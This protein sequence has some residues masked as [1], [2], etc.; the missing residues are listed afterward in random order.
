MKFRIYPILVAAS[1]AYTSCSSEEDFVDIPTDQKTEIKFSMT[2]ESGSVS[3]G[4]PMSRAGFASNTQIIARLESFK[5]TTIGVAPSTT[6]KRSTR[7]TLTAQAQGDKVYSDVTTSDPRYWDDCYGR[8]GNLSVYAV[9]VPGKTDQENG[10]GDAKKQLSELISYG[11][12]NVSTLNTQWKKDEDANT[13]NNNI[14]WEITK[15]ARVTGTSISGQ[16]STTI[17]SEDLCYSNN[18][19]S[20]GKN[21][22]YRWNY[23]ANPAG[24][25]AF[26]YTSGVE[27]EYPNF[28]NGYLRFTLPSSSAESAAG[29]FDKGHMIFKH[30]LTRLTV[31]LKRGD[32][33]ASGETYFKFKK[34]GSDESNV[35]IINVPIKNTLNIQ[36]GAWSTTSTDITSGSIEKMAPVSPVKD[37]Y[38]YSL[39][40]QFIPGYT[41]AKDNATNV[42]EFTI[43]DNTYYITQANIWKALNEN[44]A[45]NG[46]TDATSYTMEQ[47]KNY[48]LDIT[49]KKTGIANV[50]ATLVGWGEVQAANIDAGNSY[51]TIST[52][53]MGEQTTK[54]DHFDLWRA[55]A[56]VTNIYT[57]QN[58][59]TLPVMKNW[60]GN[61][62]DQATLTK[63]GA[64]TTNGKWKT[65]WYWDSNKSFYHF[66]TVDK[67]VE[68]NGA[69][70]DGADTTD[71]Y[72]NV[73]SGPAN[74]TWSDGTVVSTAVNDKKYNDYHWG[75][76]MK[77]GANLTYNVTEGT[78]EGYSESLY[79]AIGSTTDQINIIEQHMM[80]TVHFVIHTGKKADGTDVSNAAVQLL[81][82]SNN[83]TRLTLT[84]FYGQGQ[85]K[86]GNG[87]ITPSN[88][89]SSDIPVPGATTYSYDTNHKL[90]SLVTASETY[91]S[92]A[93]TITKSYDYRVVPQLLYRGSASD[94]KTDNTLSNFVGL[95]IVTPDNNQYYVIQKLYGVQGTVTSNGNKTEHGA[96]NSTSAITRWYPGYDYTYHIYINKT[97]I[98]KITC[99]VVDW[100]TVTG[101]IGDITLEN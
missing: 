39:M 40:A 34:E 19:M 17:D 16:T 84:N 73:F 14:T 25:P 50:T 29:H 28:E 66:R 15:G 63:D 5:S 55:D 82:A 64:Y 8:Y 54:C 4:T 32:G 46:L 7:M 62:T 2:D 72:F 94:P 75:A 76:P 11:G 90:S 61:Y 99:T 83:G 18:I 24:Y 30:A 89:I 44:K 10:T 71:D 1:L 98:D 37:T 53:T 87:F 38:Q 65:N 3:N 91:F 6:D 43:D 59:V 74:E 57:N 41:F 92:T 97:G 60:K 45:T 22:V 9:A 100:A 95:T 93:N 56:G 67:G 70:G 23:N 101:N 68:I 52:E 26:S 78:N 79:Q 20:G 77:T 21:G 58:G 47:G 81:D 69:T 80:S 36:E 12:V 31:N 49:V 51:I 13:S 96:T 86:M 35:K 33:F 27:D 85:V 42:L 48:I 88:L